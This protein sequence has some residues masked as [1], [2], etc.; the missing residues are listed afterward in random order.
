[1]SSWVG[2]YLIKRHNIFVNKVM[3]KAIG[4]KSVLTPAIMA[5][6]RNAQPTPDSRSAIAALPGYIVGATDMLRSIWSEREAFADKPA[7]ILWGFKDIAFRRKELE[8][9]KFELS[10]FELQEFE[11]CGHF[12]AEEAPEKLLLALR[13]F[14][15]RT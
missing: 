12:L 2:Q 8:R 13:A 3:P 14:M 7:L 6:Y 5:H 10:D 11:D 4:N 9:W 1:M 15:K